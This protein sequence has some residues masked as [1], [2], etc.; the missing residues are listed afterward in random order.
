[1]W[2]CLVSA[3]TQTNTALYTVE[4]FLALEI[5]ATSDEQTLLRTN[6]LATKLLA[7]FS[8]RLVDGQQYLRATLQSL[9]RDVCS[10][11]YGSLEVN[12]D[13]VGDEPLA[14]GAVAGLERSMRTLV[15][16]AQVRRVASQTRLIDVCSC[17]Q[18]F[19]NAIVDALERMPVSFQHLCAHMASSVQV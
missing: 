14:A 7:T 15:S 6:S 2:F 3:P 5:V 4:V 11:R 17:V 16:L 9:V 18:T 13:N 12:P 10:D 1:M 19:L 8:K